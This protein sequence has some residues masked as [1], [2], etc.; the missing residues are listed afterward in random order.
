[1]PAVV[2]MPKSVDTKST[3][4]HEAEEGILQETD[5]Y[6]QPKRATAQVIVKGKIQSWIRNNG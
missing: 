4:W 3:G 1:M 5:R 2:A 6:Q